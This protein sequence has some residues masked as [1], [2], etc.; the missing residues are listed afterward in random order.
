MSQE[1][2]LPETEDEI[3]DDRN[4]FESQL[5]FSFWLSDFIDNDIDFFNH[6]ASESLDV[7][8]EVALQI[9]YNACELS[10]K[11]NVDC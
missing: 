9:A 2:A 7:I 4:F 6:N 11:R 10:A 3:Q 5:L 8:D 1:C